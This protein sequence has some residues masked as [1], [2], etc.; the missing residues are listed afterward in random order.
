MTRSTASR[1]PRF[2]KQTL[3]FLSRASRQRNPNWLKKN[4]EDYESL[5]LLPLRNLAQSLKAEVGG[6]APSYHFP[7]KGI[8]RLRRPANRVSEWGGGLYKGWMA[9]S[10]SRPSGSRFDHNPNLF[11]LIQPEDTQDSVLVAGGLYMPSS[12]QTRAVREAIAQ[13]ASAFDRLFADRTFSKHFPGGFSDERISS[14][15]PR[16]FDPNHPRMEWLRLQAF[17]VWRSYKK[18]EFTSAKFP[19]IVA[20]DWKQILRLNELL[21]QAIQGTLPRKAETPSAKKR[22]PGVLEQ[23]QDIGNVR[24]KMDF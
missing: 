23:L 21:E 2:S 19:Q 4:Q 12:R 10:A 17:F 7:I 8:G 11:F 22:K 18:S 1:I 14:R 16:G 9:Y 13:D 3:E 5:L 15:A 24:P 6:L 20:Q